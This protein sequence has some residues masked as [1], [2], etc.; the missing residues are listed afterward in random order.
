MWLSRL[1]SKLVAKNSI[2]FPIQI[3]F[4]SGISSE[5]HHS[6]C[7]VAQGSVLGHLLFLIYIND[8][9]QVIENSED[10]L[11]ADDTT[12]LGGISSVLRCHQNVFKLKI[13]L[14]TIS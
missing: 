3:E 14:I 1:I 11:F 13:G 12:I 2:A 4:Q 6:D 9:T 5:V 8:M 7:G 10:I